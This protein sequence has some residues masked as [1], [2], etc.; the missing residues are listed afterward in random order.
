MKTLSAIAA[1][2]LSAAPLTA[3]SAQLLQ[4][5]RAYQGPARLQA[6]LAGIS[7]ALPSGT[8]AEWDPEVQG[9]LVAARGGEIL[10]GVWG[11]SEATPEEVEEGVAA[12]LAEAGIQLRARGEPDRDAEGM[13]GFFLAQTEDGPGLLH[14]IVRG[15][16]EDNAFAVAALGTAEAESELQRLTES[17]AGS[18]EW[19]RPGAAEWRGQ[20]AGTVLS[21]SGGGSD[22][23][24]GGSASGSAASQSSTTLA[25]CMGGRYR[26]ESVSETYVS[27]PGASASSESRDGHAGSWWIIA[28]LVG[29]AS[30]WLETDDGRTLQWAVVE[31][32]DAYLVDGTRYVVSGGG[33]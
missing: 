11:W 23:S 26:Y 9:L 31:E 6:P 4:A 32:G 19:S 2:L 27:I 10:A 21:A 8:Q 14:A 7:F 15:G 28:D 18:V 5:G 16:T 12:L 24:S 33:C 3:Q 25:L 13:S 17:I 1:V 30:L 29:G 22:Y 20:V